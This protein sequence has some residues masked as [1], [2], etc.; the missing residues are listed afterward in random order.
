MKLTTWTYWV[1]G[2]WLRQTWLSEGT[3][4]HNI[5]WEVK[6]WKMWKWICLVSVSDV[7]VL[8]S[9]TSYKRILWRRCL[10]RKCNRV[11]RSDRAYDRAQLWGIHHNSCSRTIEF[12]P[13]ANE[14]WGKVIFLHLS[15]ILFTRG[16]GGSTWAGTPMSRYTPWAGTPPRGRY[17][18]GQVHPPAGTPLSPQAGITP[19]GRYTP[20]PGTPPGRYPPSSACWDTVNKRAVRI[21][22][23]C[24]LVLLYG[25][26]AYFALSYEIVF[27]RLWITDLV[28][29]ARVQF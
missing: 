8:Q 14:V 13:P 19:P 24:I 16:G 27:S 4:L 9:V 18:P 29:S 17:T 3:Y 12:L 23:E 25:H 6:R 21:L 7:F 10:G 26:F 2:F 1:W 20:Q 11:W 15:V 22:L 28:Q 5:M